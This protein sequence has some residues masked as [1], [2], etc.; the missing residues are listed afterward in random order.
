M[1]KST[2]K[3]VIPLPLFQ[4]FVVPSGMLFSATRFSFFYSFTIAA[5][6]LFAG[7]LL[8]GGCALGPDYAAPKKEGVE[9]KTYREVGQWK[10]AVPRDNLPKGEWW[11]VYN[12]PSLDR[13]V[14]LG[15]KNSPTPQAALARLEQARAAAGIEGAALLPKIA[16]DAA[17]SRSRTAFNRRTGADAYTQ[18]SFS[19][20]VDL[21]YEIDLWGRV[22]RKNEAAA[23]RAEAAAGDYN[24]TLLTL[25]A[26]IAR[27]Y[28]AIR[29]LDAEHALELR[30]IVSRR[31]SLNVVSRRQEL[32][33]GTKLD[34][35][36]AEA[37]LAAA[38]A[39]LA[40]IARNRASLLHALATLCGQSTFDFALAADEKIALADPPD[41]PIGLPSE[42][43]ERRPDVAAAERALAAANAEI[44]A[45][46]AA[47]FPT[48]VLFAN[49]GYASASAEN[50]I[51]P[52]QWTW[53][54]GP[55]LTMP[56]FEGGR[57]RAAH[58]QARAAHAEAF[59]NYRAK[60]L[61]AF[62][63]VETCLS[64]LQHLAARSAALRR[65]AV[66]S[67]EAAALAYERYTRGYDNYM[68]ALTA[69]RI[70]IANERLDVQVRGAQLTA[71][72]LLV[73][74]IG[75]GW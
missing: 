64:D 10:T 42:L 7:G 39:E 20:G 66:A 2:P 63:E 12:D 45:A 51:T 65:A 60:V 35:R 4:K 44:G 48:I 40:D 26:D 6:A 11:R 24:N 38:E 33:A 37:E 54:F 25:Q 9:K 1:L 58:E 8:T 34:T 22:R 3:N 56:F 36:L 62:A 70:A 75:G 13:L 57:L 72:V 23:A 19:L 49:A 14:N 47:F 18:N 68:D 28:F 21:T 73:K 50:L 41:I 71:S 15:L 59:A 29:A 74:A 16:G 30:A 46:K 31:N 17:A 53:N 61:G 69:E 5:L 43:L 55:T 32:G 52:K 67:K 27:T